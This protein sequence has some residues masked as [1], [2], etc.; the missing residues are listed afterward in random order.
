MATT[1]RKR[2]QS[3]EGWLDG[4]SAREEEVERRPVPI[5]LIAFIVALLFIALEV[6]GVIL[7]LDSQYA[8]ATLIGQI[9]TLGTAL[10]L[11][12][13]LAAVITGWAR[14]WGVLAVLLSVL[15]NPLVL[16]AVLD[17]ASRL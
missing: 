8:A 2:T 14:G 5:G 13:G 11:L 3:S 16:N 15:A 9:V 10:P 12:L 6:V 4:L 7:A 17:G 1:P